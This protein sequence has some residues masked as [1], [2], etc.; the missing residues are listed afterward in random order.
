MLFIFFNIFIFDLTLLFH[1]RYFRSHGLKAQTIIFPN[2][3]CGH[4]FVTS[5]AHNDLG[6]MNMSNVYDELIRLLHNERL[7]NGQYPAIYC[8]GIF[9][10]RPYII[11]RYVLNMIEYMKRVNMRMASQR[12]FVEHYYRDFKLYFLFFDHEKRLKLMVAKDLI[13]KV[14]LLGF[15]LLNCYYCFNKS[16]SR[17][18]ELLA[19]DIDEYLAPTEEEMEEGTVEEI[20]ATGVRTRAEGDATITGEGN[21][22][23]RACARRR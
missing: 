4:A 8:D 5:M 20:G 16:S 6:V 7:P 22:R 3:M 12:V 9:T 21:E 11:P 15:F 1:S 2:G 10:A 19:P 18:F 13:R 17:N 23:G 14:I